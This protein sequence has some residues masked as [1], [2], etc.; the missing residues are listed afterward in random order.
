[1]LGVA[2]TRLYEEL[3]APRVERLER[4]RRGN[5]VHQHA[6]VGAAVERHAERLEALLS[7]RVPNL[8]R[9]QPVAH[10]HLL[11]EEVGADRRLVLAAESAVH[12]LVHERRLAHAAEANKLQYVRGVL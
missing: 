5:V 1:M 3:V 2:R 9:H 11:R 6:A 8:H 4:V 7:G 10:R 12:V